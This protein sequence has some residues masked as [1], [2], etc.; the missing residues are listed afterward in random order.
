MSIDI[1]A[2]ERLVNDPVTRKVLTISKREVLGLINRL[3]EAEKGRDELKARI[4]GGV[5]AYAFNIGEW[6]AVEVFK[7]TT[8]YEANATLILDDGV[9][10]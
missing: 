2:I 10:S 7:H 4:D 5:R 1:D 9:E 6:E 3:R 8:V